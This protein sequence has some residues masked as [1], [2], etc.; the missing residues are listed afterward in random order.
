ME[1]LTPGS[2]VR[3]HQRSPNLIRMG[4]ER[5]MLWMIAI[6]FGVASNAWFGWNWTPKSDAEVICDGIV[7]LLV[8]V[9]Y[10]ADKSQTI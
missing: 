3:I 7:L 6:I 8:A 4:A 10:A 1:L 5:Q 9:A 2:M